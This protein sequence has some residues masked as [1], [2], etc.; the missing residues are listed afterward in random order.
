MAVTGVSL[1]GQ[2]RTFHQDEIIVSKTDLKGKIAYANDVFLRVS[3]FT[4]EELLGQP[5]NIVRHPDMPRCIYKF[6]WDR[7]QAGNEIFAYVI[8]RAKNGDHYWVFAH[9]TPVFGH[10]RAI[11]G[12]HSSRRLPTRKAVEAAAGLY[13][14]LRAEEAKHADRGAAMT[15]AGALLGNILRDKGTTYDEFVFSL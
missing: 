4:E 6:L 3:G 5:H 8:N 9:V 13:A 11:T 7:I 14:L 10:D 2:E 15:A 12:Y 1:S